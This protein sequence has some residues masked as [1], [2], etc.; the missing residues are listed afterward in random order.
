MVYPVHPRQHQHLV[1][2][3]LLNDRGHETVGVEGDGLHV[4]RDAIGARITLTF[5]DGTKLVREVKASRGT[6]NSMDTRLLYFGLGDLGCE[7]DVEVRWPD[8]TV[9]HAT[10]YDT[11]V[12]MV[13]GF[14]Y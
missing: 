10:A 5:P 1:G 14:G 2:A 8:G 4:T 13:S 11:G 9:D 3:L 12:D 6:Y 7:F